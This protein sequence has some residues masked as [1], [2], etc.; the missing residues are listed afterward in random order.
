LLG[1]ARRYELALA[2]SSE[3]SSG[4]SIPA[5]LG[6]LCH[7]SL[8]RATETRTILS[9]QWEEGLSLAWQESLAKLRERASESPDPEAWPG[10]KVAKA[11]MRNVASRLRDILFP[12]GKEVELICEQRMTALDGRLV[13]K[14]DLIINC[15][16]GPWIV[17]YKTGGVF[18][19]ETEQPREEYATQLHLYAVLEH[20]RSQAWATRGILLPFSQGSVDIQLERGVCERLAAMVETAIEE[21]NE[22]HPDLQPAA[23]SPPHCQWCGGATHCGAVWGSCEE[24]WAPKVGLAQG[25]VAQVARSETGVTTIVL[26]LEAGTLGRGRI[27]I[28]ADPARATGLESIKSGAR[29]RA[30]GLRRRRG[31]RTFSLTPW[32]DLRGGSA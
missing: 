11:R 19:F 16:E 9:E 32:S 28:M 10:F 22:R 8:Q 6:D 24:S 14:P 29:L 31:E 12:L 4:F 20:S 7:E 13:G 18:D 27:A 3:A 17:D 1:C 15:E 2:S 23:P 25:T 26:D 30:A 21:F 5:A